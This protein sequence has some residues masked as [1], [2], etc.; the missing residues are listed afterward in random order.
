MGLCSNQRIEFIDVSEFDELAGK[1]RGPMVGI[2]FREMLW[3]GTSDRSVL[4]VVLRDLVDK[5]FSWVCLALHSGQYE[6][7]DVAV[8]IATQAEALL[9]VQHR[10]Q[11]GYSK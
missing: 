10:M 9:A 2:L 5:D 8:S 3:L 4:G 1:V 6:A 7:V 11:H